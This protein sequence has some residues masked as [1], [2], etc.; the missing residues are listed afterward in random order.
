MSEAAIDSFWAAVQRAEPKEWMKVARTLEAM[1]LLVIDGCTHQHVI[2]NYFA[3]STLDTIAS[4]MS[5]SIFLDGCT[6]GKQHQDK[7][8]RRLDGY[9]F[10]CVRSMSPSVFED[11]FVSMDRANK[12]LRVRQ[13]YP[14][15]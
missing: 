7:I 12:Y 11:F 10:H 14:V 2:Q 4:G 3:V 13:G 15:V 8:C 6:L 9:I 5:A 1:K